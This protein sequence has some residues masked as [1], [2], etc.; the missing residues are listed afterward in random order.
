M[1]K[2]IHYTINITTTKAELFAIRCG[3]NQAVQ[4][5]NTTHIIIIITDVI[6]TARQIF[7]LLTHPYQLYSITIL[8]D[9]RAFFNKSSNNFIAF[10]NYSSST[11]WIHYSAVNEKTK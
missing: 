4:V 5:Q 3:I 11:K 6:H 1:P 10:K 9:L 2:K 8:Q 7:D